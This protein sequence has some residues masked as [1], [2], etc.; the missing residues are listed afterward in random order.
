MDSTSK[1]VDFIL[2]LARTI[3]EIKM[4]LLISQMESKYNVVDE[5]SE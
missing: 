3:E 4:M 5:I 2:T 1:R